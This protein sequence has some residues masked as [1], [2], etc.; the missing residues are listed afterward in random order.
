MHCVETLVVV[1]SSVNSVLKGNF[2]SLFLEMLVVKV[3]YYCG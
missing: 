1:P 3:F 2:Y